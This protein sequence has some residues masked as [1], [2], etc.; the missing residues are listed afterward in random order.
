MTACEQGMDSAPELGGVQVVALGLDIIGERH[1]IGIPP[2]ISRQ[3]V[4][5]RTISKH[6]DGSYAGG[7][8]LLAG[9]GR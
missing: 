9:Y 8:I 1:T 4:A 5:P 2:Q 3:I 6:G 7:G